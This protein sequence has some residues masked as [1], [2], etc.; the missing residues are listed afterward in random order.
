MNKD[1]GDITPNLGMERIDTLL[2][3]SSN[4]SLSYSYP[5]GLNL[6]TGGVEIS[7]QPQFEAKQP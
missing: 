4:Y 7:H 3:G 5:H 2:F 1:F 6:Q